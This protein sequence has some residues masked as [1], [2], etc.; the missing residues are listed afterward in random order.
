MPNISPLLATKL[1]SFTAKLPSLFLTLILL[2]N[3]LSATFSGSVLLISKSTFVPTII[4]VNSLMLVSL[5]LTVAICSPF[6]KIATL[7]LISITSLSLWVMIT[8]DLPFFLIFLIT[9]K[10]C[11]ISCGVKTAV[12]S[13]RIKISTL[14]YKALTISNVCFSLTVML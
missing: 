14:R 9:S 11:L 2:T 8:M 1:T 6:L 13:S 12:G 5:V 3:N 10:R 4:S 7:S